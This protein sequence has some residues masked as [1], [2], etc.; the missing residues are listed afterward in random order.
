M[1]D[2][3]KIADST[4]SLDLSGL[5]LAKNKSYSISDIYFYEA[6]NILKASIKYLSKL[7]NM[8]LAPFDYDFFLRIHKEML[9]DVWDWAGK[10]R[11]VELNFG[12]KA[13]MINTEL[14]KLVDDLDFWHKNK[15]FDIIEIAARVHHRAVVIHPFLNGNGRWSRMLANIYLKQ[16]GLEPTKWNENILAKENMHR[17]DYIK[18]L[19][20]ADKGDYSYLIKMQAK[21]I[22]NNI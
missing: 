9:G 13:Y 5:K 2:R 1:N 8:K 16:N 7:P 4:Y 15:N 22:N 17:D 20:Q 10:I 12:I 21:L 6:Q 18:A 11:T 19:K 14:K 3:T